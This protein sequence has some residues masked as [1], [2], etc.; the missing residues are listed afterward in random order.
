MSSSSNAPAVAASDDADA[1]KYETSKYTQRSDF[2][3]L[4]YVVLL[5]ASIFMIS[6]YYCFDN[7]SALHDL[8]KDW[9]AGTMS[10]ADFERNYNLMFTVYAVPNIILPF[11]GGYLV[12]RYGYSSMNIVFCTFLLVGQLVTSY[13][14]AQKNM[15]LALLGRV[16]FGVG[17]ECS[18][19]GISSALTEWFKGSG[20]TAMAMAI[21]L[22]LSRLG[23]VTNNLVSPAIAN[24]QGR[25]AS[26]FLFGAIII[27]MGLIACFF[28]F[29]FVRY[30]RGKLADNGIDVDA[31][32]QSEESDISVW[33]AFTF[34]RSFWLLTL[35][36][37]VLYG[38]IIPFNSIASALIIEKFLCFGA[39]CADTD[40]RCALQLSS[41]KTASFWMSI[42]YI[43]SACLAPIM[44]FILDRV[45][46]N[47][48]LILASGFGI[49]TVH[50]TIAAASVSELLIPAL[51]LQGLTYSVYAAALWP[52][53][54]LSVPAK[55][56][57]SAYGT[58]FAVQNGGL[59]VIPLIVAALRNA[60]GSYV[61]VEF[62]FASLGVV[63]TIVGFYLIHVDSVDNDKLLNMSAS[64]KEERQKKAEDAAKTDE[65][66]QISQRLTS[67][68]AMREDGDDS[69]GKDGEQNG[70]A[71]FARSR[72]NRVSGQEKEPIHSV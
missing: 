21:Q 61:S 2:I 15:F 39:C 26:A 30:T 33:E 54:A 49:V 7:P 1:S 46:G 11:F 63:A 34:K 10:S 16:L 66:N 40:P 43:I 22:S 8:L 5:C 4:R 19:V 42:P 37:V 47:V 55:S 71:E 32:T 17:G 50:V 68:A 35:S 65:E 24:V 64:E 9:F 12:D 27:G 28:I 60:T 29:C 18:G 52:C 20:Q 51:V 45:G 59:A 69:D 48:V 41:E 14:I 56:V 36:C 13:G 58:A 44:G 3:V 67:P 23:S 62:F 25:P 6:N 70:E 38:C 57:G 53:I 31:A 72:G